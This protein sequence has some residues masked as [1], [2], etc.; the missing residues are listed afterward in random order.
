MNF[1][2]SNTGEFFPLEFPSEELLEAAFD[3]INLHTDEDWIVDSGTSAHF[4]G[5]RLAFRF[6]KTKIRD[7]SQRPITLYRGIGSC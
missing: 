6:H 1:L 4:S 7:L 3:A 5:D 2:D